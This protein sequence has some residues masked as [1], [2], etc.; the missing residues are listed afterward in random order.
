MCGCVSMCVWV[1]VCLALRALRCFGG[2][3]LLVG[4]CPLCRLGPLCW[5]CL[6]APCLSSFCLS[7]PFR[8]CATP[9]PHPT[10]P[11]LP[12][13]L[14]GASSLLV[15]GFHHFHSSLVAPLCA[16]M[17][18]P[19]LSHLGAP[20]PLR[21]AP[22]SPSVP[23]MSTRPCSY[24]SWWPTCVRSRSPHLPCLSGWPRAS[25]PRVVGC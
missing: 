22:T 1:G 13:H 6:S 10:S 2:W 24:L 8:S 17:Y 15:P 21:L 4:L 19:A 18:G 23:F 12:S 16:Y 3:C 9:P 7:L 14:P 5:F 11:T 25:S 20:S